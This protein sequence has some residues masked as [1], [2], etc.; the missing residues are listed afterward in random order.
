MVQR[1]DMAVIGAAVRHVGKTTFACEL[2]RRHAAEVPVVAAKVTTVHGPRGA[3]CSRG[4]A[5][6]GACAEFAGPFCLSEETVGPPGKDTT[7]LLRAG[8]A[9]VFWLRVRRESLADGVH[10]L[11]R[12]IPPGM[13]CVCESNSVRQ[14]LEPG[15]FLVLTGPDG[16]RPKPSCAEVLAHADRVVHYDGRGWDLAPADVTFAAGRWVLRQPAAAVILAGGQSRRMGTDKSLLPIRGVPLIQHLARQLL[17]LFERVLISANDAGRYAFLQLP[18]IA[19]LVPGQGPLMAIASSLPATE[20]ELNFVIACDT[21][22]V[23]PGFV[24]E[25]LRLADGY[26]VVM[27]VSPDGRHEPLFAVYR[28]SV[29]ETARDLLRRGSRRLTDLIGHARVRLVDLPAG[30]WYRNLNTP[31]DYRDA[32]GYALPVEPHPAERAP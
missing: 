9:R 3:A 19:D 30:G 11:L 4:G 18:V 23:D 14:V 22:D 31:E 10:E 6:C 26:D 7:R 17:P 12:R 13:A 25:M 16:T 29:A 28:T 21:P 8:A 15:V 27:P 32:T 24:L 20:R 5:G 2:I 1:P